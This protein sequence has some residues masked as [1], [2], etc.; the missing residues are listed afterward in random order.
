MATKTTTSKTATGKTTTSA[1]GKISADS[2]RKRAEEIYRERVNNGKHGD[3]L[4]DWLQAEKE[5]KSIY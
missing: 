4:S 3:E 5:L 1:K 2:I